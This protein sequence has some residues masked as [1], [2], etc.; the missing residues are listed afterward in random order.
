MCVTKLLSL[1]PP[2][3]RIPFCSKKE[4]FHLFQST[5]YKYP[6]TENASF[7]NAFQRGDF[8]KRQLLIY[9]WTEENGG[10]RLQ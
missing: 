8:W 10:F 5:V 4:F 7:Q 6:V 1:R 3:T 9:T 2:P